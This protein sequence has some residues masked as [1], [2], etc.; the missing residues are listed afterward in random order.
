MQW[1][2]V[3]SALVPL[4]G[5]LYILIYV[6]TTSHAS[7]VAFGVTVGAVASVAGLTLAGSAVGSLRGLVADRS[8]VRIARGWRWRTIPLADVSGVGLLFQYTPGLG[9]R[10]LPGWY[11]TIWSVHGGRTQVE[12]LLVS[13]TNWTPPSTPQNQWR[14]PDEDAAAL[15]R[16][17]PGRAAIKLTELVRRLQGED[18]PLATRH[19]EKKVA[20]DRFA[21]PQI[22]AWWSPDGTVGRVH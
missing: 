11:L 6:L 17:K 13:A 15:A 20:S 10:P 21:A 7:Y 8:A 3:L 2:A 12:Q 4:G 14:L 16:S 19:D 22:V 9:R 1:L 5:G 18:G